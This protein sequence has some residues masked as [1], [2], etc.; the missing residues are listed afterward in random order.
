MLIDLIAATAEEAEAIMSTP[1]HANVWPTLEARTVDQIKLASLAFILEGKPPENEAVTAYVK[2]FR[3][4]ANGGEE[5]PWIDLV[6]SDL[7]EGLALLS[8]DQIA[9]A[10]KAW[11]STEAAKRDRW[12]A[13]DV[14][15][16]LRELSAFA[17]SARAQQREVLLWACL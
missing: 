8:D 16:L 9:A 3:K 2:G 7:V 14:E 11:A 13:K 12:N 10:A 6:P 1:G 15:P 5:G 4:L 17:G